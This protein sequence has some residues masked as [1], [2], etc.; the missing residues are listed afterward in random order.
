M[1]VHFHLR[2]LKGDNFHRFG[3]VAMEIENG[4]ITNIGVAVCNERDQFNPVIGRAMAYGR[5]DKRDRKS[6]DVSI[7]IPEDLSDPSAVSEALSRVI[8]S[9]CDARAIDEITSNINYSFHSRECNV[10]AFAGAI[11]SVLQSV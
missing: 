1:R 8:D 2:K 3:T 11:K 4:A 5:L 10:N 9:A 6:K 7:P